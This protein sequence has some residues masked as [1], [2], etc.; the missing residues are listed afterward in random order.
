[1]DRKT[2]ATIASYV[3]DM[4]ALEH[5]IEDALTGQIKDLEDDRESA[6]PL[7]EIRDTCTQHARALQRIADAREQTGQGVSE[8]VK[9]AAASVMGAGA[10]AIDFVRTEK[11]PKLLRD[12]YTAASLA[13]IGYVMLHTTA[14]SLGDDEVAELSHV[15][16]Q[17]H[18]K[19]V[20]TLH[21]IIPGAV[22]RFLQSEGHPAT[23]DVLPTIS[24][25]L[26]SVWHDNAGVPD[27]EQG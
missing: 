13:V 20:M 10:A 5:H 16:L 22:I 27:V 1:M 11:V 2:E 23:A 3:T 8:I 21:N 9:K 4:L 7:M 24:E 14:L 26:E 15:H 6:P 19:S 25:N 17:N 18:A 12:D